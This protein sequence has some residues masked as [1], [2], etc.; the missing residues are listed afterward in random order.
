M[1]LTTNQ[2]AQFANEYSQEQLCEFGRRLAQAANQ[3]ERVQILA[4]FN[5][6]LPDPDYNSH[7]QM[8]QLQAAA[9]SAL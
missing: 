4:E 2:L 5:A 3:D 9:R 8:V 7:P 1:A 6:N